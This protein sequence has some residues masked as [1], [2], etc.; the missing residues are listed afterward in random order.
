MGTLGKQCELAV[1]DVTI[2]RCD[3][4]ESR[5]RLAERHRGVDDPRGRGEALTGVHVGWRAVKGV[6]ADALVSVCLSSFRACRCSLALP[7]SIMDQWAICAP[8]QFR[9]GQ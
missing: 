7:T 1:E 2:S 9:E 5:V 3:T 8:S 6:G 4:T